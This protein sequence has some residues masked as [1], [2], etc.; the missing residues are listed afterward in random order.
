MGLC[1]SRLD[2]E[3]TLH[4]KEEDAPRPVLSKE[5][6]VSRDPTETAPVLTD[7]QAKEQLAVNNGHGTS[8]EEDRQLFED[9]KVELFER[10]ESGD[11]GEEGRKIIL[12]ATVKNIWAPVHYRG[13]YTHQVW[14]DTAWNK[15]TFMDQYLQIMSILIRI[16]FVRWEQF[17]TIF[18]D[19]KDRRDTNL[20]FDL[21]V[22]Q[23]KDFLGKV[24][25]KNF[26]LAQWA[27]CPIHI[28]EQEDEY[29]LNKEWRLPWID[30]PIE[31]GQGAFG[32]VTK[33]TVATG[34]LVY[35]DKTV[36]PKVSH[37]LKGSPWALAKSFS[38]AKAV[39]IKT[40][41]DKDARK[42]EFQNLKDLRK[43][44][45]NH[46]RIMVN[47]ATMIE[48]SS[49]S[50]TMYHIVYELAAYDLNVFLTTMPRTLRGKRHAT[51]SPERTNSANMWPGDLISES[52][53]LADAL[54]YL[55]NRLYSESR[56][57]LSHNDIKP[58]NILVVYPD[59][60]NVNDHFP[61]GKWKI[62]DFGL[63]KVKLKRAPGSKHL[64]AQ[65]ADLTPLQ[66]QRT[67]RTDRT[68]S[69]SKT[70]P[71][72][73]P[74]QYTAPEL[75]QSTPQ[76]TDSRRA[77]LWSFGCVLSEIVTYAVKLDCQLVENFR[78]SLGKSEHPDQRDLPDERFYHHDTKEVKSQFLS[79][80]AK[81]PGT[82]HGDRR[83]PHHTQ[84]IGSCVDLVKS[85]VVTD[86]NLRL[87]A[88]RVRDRLREID[89]SMRPERNEW[90]RD[91]LARIS[92]DT[93]YPTAHTPGSATES[94]TD[95]DSDNGRDDA[96]SRTPSICI[97]PPQHTVSES[98]RGRSSLEDKRRRATAPR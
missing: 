93:A 33:Q 96:F 75:D 18:I 76:K 29:A 67:H 9:I 86:P 55:H 64:S 52:G 79:H 17:G 50:G 80:L 10:L 54:D 31:I 21:K 46:T 26:F 88:N 1:H 28:Q 25:G 34:F 38:Q 57:S 60:T 11:V 74:G 12:P 48:K 30:D 15:D 39:A 97:T 41:S 77:D 27:F 95:I 6:Q 36:N 49:Q 3:R 69:V 87:G 56:I 73:D 37:L 32:R 45:S 82:A 66:A 42:V 24:A 98:T 65:E 51:A 62:A 4:D 35:E 5:R 40:V 92:T 2:R 14:Y 53:N 94:P 23:R 22:L 71:K 68:G 13:F 70:I 59:S 20:P 58:E 90:L 72:R 19:Q 81:L 43:C 44:L 84:W 85:I 61:V 91:D 89:L 8:T 47:L 16:D 83:L 7:A 78:E 63:S